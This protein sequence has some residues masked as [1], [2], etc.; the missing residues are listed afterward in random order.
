MKW[1]GFVCSDNYE[2]LERNA[3]RYCH[4]LSQLVLLLV[5][6]MYVAVLQWSRQLN[7]WESL[8]N[9][10]DASNKNRSMNIIIDFSEAP[11][12]TK[13][14]RIRYLSFFIIPGK[15]IH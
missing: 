8:S 7:W 1:V 11:Y 9:F 3:F 15:K 2:F 10:G 4:R 5:L 13:T 12:L 6:L 14:I